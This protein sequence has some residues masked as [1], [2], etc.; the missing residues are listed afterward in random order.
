MKTL[1]LGKYNSFQHVKSPRRIL[2][3]LA[4]YQFASKLI[5]KDRRVLD[6]GCNEGQGTYLLGKECGYAY[7]TDF[8]EEAIEAAKRNY[9]SD[10]VEFTTEDFFD[11]DHLPAWDA[12]TSF[13]VI[14]HIYPEHADEFVSKMA[15]KINPDGMVILGTPSLTS[16]QYASKVTNAGHVNL[17]TSEG[18]EH[19]L[20]KFFHNT[21]V[22]L[23]NDELVHLG[24][25]PL[26]HYLLGIGCNK[27]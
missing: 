24:F 9:T 5:G 7:G 8:D 21:F 22:F 2:H 4:Y 13:D 3:S 17:Y 19:Q 12:I 18:L 14:E 20:D 26:G 1:K 23:A 25:P 6:V 10:A 27:K 11:A 16:K 15:E